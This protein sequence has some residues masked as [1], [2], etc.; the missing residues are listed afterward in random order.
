MRS[1]CR[2]SIGPY[3][4][5]AASTVIYLRN[6]CATNGMHELTPYEIVVGRKPILSHLNV[7]G[8]I[9]NERIPNKKREKFNTKLEKCILVGYSSKQK[10]YKCFNPSTRVVRVSRDVDF[11]ESASWYKPDSTPSIPT[12]EELDVNSDDN[13]QPSPLPK[14]RPSSIELT[15]AQ[16]PSS[17]PSTSQLGAKL[18][19]GK[20]KMPEYEVNHPDNSDPD[21]LAPLLDSG[22]DVHITRTPGVKKALT[23]ANE[24]LC[25]SS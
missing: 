12:K 24:K 22:F 13:I 20:G 25:R 15:G 14:D 4:A 8:S 6:R 1:T 21:V 2:T 7:F 5:K 9:K 17:I 19:K 3:W 23:S 18:H 11:D 16:E 10:A